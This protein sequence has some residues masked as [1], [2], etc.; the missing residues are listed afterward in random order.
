MALSLSTGALGR[1]LMQRAHAMPAPDRDFPLTMGWMLIGCAVVGLLLGAGITF[2]VD[3]SD[4]Q[5]PGSR[6]R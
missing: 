3:R 2:W 5:P 6:P 1:L 4:E